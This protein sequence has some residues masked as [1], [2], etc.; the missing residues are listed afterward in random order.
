M[1]RVRDYRLAMVSGLLAATGGACAYCGDSLSATEAQ[2]DHVDPRGPDCVSN[3]LPACGPCNSSK[4][5]KSLEDYRTFIEN[6]AAQDA[7]PEDLGF[8]SRQLGWLLDQCWFPIGR[9]HHVFPFEI[10]GAGL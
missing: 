2:V 4:G 8:S 5:R 1:S 7:I 10:E 3:Y 6:I 9:E